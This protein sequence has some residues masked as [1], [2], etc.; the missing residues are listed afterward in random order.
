MT[1]LHRCPRWSDIK[2]SHWTRHQ[3]LKH[4]IM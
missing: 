1:N 2:E 3:F 4:L